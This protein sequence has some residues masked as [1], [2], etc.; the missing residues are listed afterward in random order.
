MKKQIIA[1]AISSIMI[2]SMSG[3]KSLVDILDS[4]TPQT[5]QSETAQENIVSKKKNKAPQNGGTINLAIYNVDTL[6]PI[7]TQSESLKQAQS[8]IYD[9]LLR[10]AADKSITGNL[11]EDY[12][13][14]SN[15][16][17]V[18]FT[19]KQG[20]LFHDGHELTARDVD[21]TIKH[22]RKTDNAYTGMLANVVR[23][24]TEGTYTYVFKLNGPD[25]HFLY[26]MDF[27]ILEQGTAE[28]TA[29]II[30]GTGPYSIEKEVTQGDITLKANEKWHGGKRP[31]IDN[32]ILKYFPSKDAVSSALNAKEVNAVGSFGIDYLSYTP[33]ESVNMKKT[34]SQNLCFLGLNNQ[35]RYLKNQLARWGIEA[36][37]DKEQLRKKVMLDKCDV[38]N[39][40]LSPNAFYTDA[41]LNKSRYNLSRAKNIMDMNVLKTGSHPAS[42]S[43][44]VCDSSAEKL[45]VAQSIQDMLIAGGLQAEVVSA[46]YETYSKRIQEKNYDM[47]VGEIN[48]ATDGD[49]SFL[50]GSG[51]WFGYE[52]EKMN[53]ALYGVKT[54]TNAEEY[55]MAYKT[56]SNL[57]IKECAFI[58]LYFKQ[59]A[60][61][62][63]SRIQGVDTTPSFDCYQNIA[64]WYRT[65]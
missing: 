58:P 45:K 30:P 40:P 59:S 51:N 61:I 62:Y 37:I 14:S 19:L 47:F 3:C 48:L 11:A 8:L 55:K 23:S 13:I 27:P 32:V 31:Y 21:Y 26:H 35:N 53:N 6:D 46:D 52:T 16:K 43:I 28:S 49:V 20:V 5:T 10:V 25:Y 12:T 9:G 38:T 50:L 7:Y 29:K 42:F 15:G 4:T 39:L 24:Y 17:V 2:F 36:L 65:E 1:I 44:L 18:R 22:I 33:T 34:D 64:G 57:M 56:L 41:A 54:S 60:L 63:D